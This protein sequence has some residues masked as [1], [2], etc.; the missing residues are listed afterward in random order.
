[1]N[2]ALAIAAPLLTL[3]EDSGF[4]NELAQVRAHAVMENLGVDSSRITDS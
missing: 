4:Q 1:M 3:I 2:E